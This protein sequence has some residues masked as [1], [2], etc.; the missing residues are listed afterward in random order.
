M[1]R[2]GKKNHSRQEK[3]ENLAM[4]GKTGRPIKECFQIPSTNCSVKI[5]PKRSYK[6]QKIDNQK[7]CMFM[8]HLLY[9][10][11]SAG[12]Q[13]TQQGITSQNGL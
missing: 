10:Q 3:Y 7:Q 6:Q 8:D 11:Y 2:E 1:P 13:N 12:L 9:A 4:I 5:M